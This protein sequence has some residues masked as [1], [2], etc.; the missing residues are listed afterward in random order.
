MELPIVISITTWLGVVRAGLI[1]FLL[2]AVPAWLAYRQGCRKAPLWREALGYIPLGLALF[3]ANR[4][5]LFKNELATSLLTQLPADMVERAYQ[6][7]VQG[8]RHATDVQGQSGWVNLQVWTLGKK[9]DGVLFLLRNTTQEHTE[10]QPAKESDRKFISRVAHEM[11][12]PL[13]TISSAL[14]TAAGDKL[15]TEERR[16][17]LQKARQQ[18]EEL[19]RLVTSV[20]VLTLLDAGQP[21][22]PPRPYKI[23][24]VAREIVDQLSE[25]AEARQM[26][27]AVEAEPNLPLVK[28]DVGVWREIFLNLISNSIKY[29]KQGGTVRVEVQHKVSELSILVADDGPGIPPDELPHLFDEGFRGTGHSDIE[30]SGLGLAIVY[31]GVKQ[32]GGQIY[33]ESEPGRGATFYITLPL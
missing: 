8:Q 15:T 12:T 19:K 33:C 21:L 27:L 6:V 26:S 5:P 9:S 3:T 4:Q 11:F 14:D 18:M 2:M 32:H 29:G 10:P 31:R 1:L 30:G 25:Q 23:T 28:L 24:E 7:R 17:I 20:R 13:N 16:I 22:Q